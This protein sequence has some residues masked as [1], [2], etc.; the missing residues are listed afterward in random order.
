MVF[1]TTSDKITHVLS[2]STNLL[3]L[4]IIG[5]SPRYCLR[6]SL[7]IFFILYAK[8]MVFSSFARHY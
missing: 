4:K 7:N 3:I 8:F 1:Q 2:Y 5:L 6:I